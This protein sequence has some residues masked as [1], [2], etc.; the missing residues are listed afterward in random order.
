MMPKQ[1]TKQ[2]GLPIVC[3]FLALMLWAGPVL[4]QGLVAAADSAGTWVLSPE[5]DRPGV[6]TLLHRAHSDP[7]TQINK[8]Q[9]LRGDVLPKC[10]AASGHTLWIIYPDGEVQAIAA[11]PSILQDGWIYRTRVESS[12]PRGISVR[13]TG[14][15]S[16]GPWV[17]VRVEEREALRELDAL[18]VSAHTARDDEAALRRR[19][20]AIG[21]PPRRGIE[22]KVDST[23]RDEGAAAKPDELPEEA[24]AQ[25]QSPSPQADETAK[26]EALALPVDRL[27]QLEHGSWRVHPLPEDWV[28][29]AKAWLVT[30]DEQADHP[31]LVARA[32]GQVGRQIAAFDV[33]HHFDQDAVHWQHQ[34]YTLDAAPDKAGMAFIGV[35]SLLVA[36]QFMFDGG[37]L[38][39]DLSV[40]R[41]GKV[42][43]VGRMELRDVS[44]N[45]WTLLGTGNTASL[46]AQSTGRDTTDNA[47]TSHLEFEWARLD[48]RGHTVLD[49]TALAIKVR[50]PMDDLM[51]YVMLAFIAVLVTVL[52][53]AFW[54][55][56]ASWNKLE[57][58]ATLV[59]ADLG[60]RATAAAIDMAP[61]ML[62]AMYYFGLD[63]PELLLRWPGNGIANS[64]EQV[65]PG[66]IVIVAFVTHTTI[67][68]LIFARTLGKAVTGLRTTA[69]DGSRPKAWQLLVRG[70]LKTLDLIPG[71]WLLLMLPVIA[72]HRQRLGDLVGRTVVVS[73]APPVE[74]NNNS[75]G[76]D[77]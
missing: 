8:V 11:E 38:L 1:Y 3:A 59:V 35:E 20:I 65:V 41:G 22:D 32:T 4:A 15:S 66:T 72:P 29:G 67:S 50:S 19:N 49:Q 21:L 6:F 75:E 34:A 26:P 39:A 7:P 12:L 71:A 63:F 17:L 24:D 36:A 52:M 51:Q 54:R 56:D 48:I 40:L 27:L 16:T 2:C 61:G 33:Y 76:E 5:P 28:H 18:G 62:G 47:A 44:P 42:L 30:E 73:D 45:D 10:V 58:P 31:T 14:V 13:A 69:L 23:P 46:I 37:L 74:E 25:P 68:E 77:D 60:R 53:L 70:L 57:L 64:I 43:P 55:R 9:T